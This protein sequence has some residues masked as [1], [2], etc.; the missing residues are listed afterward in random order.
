MYKTEPSGKKRQEV[1]VL[2]D[3]ANLYQIENEEW[4]VSD[5]VKEHGIGGADEV[6][7]IDNNKLKSYIKHINSEKG[8]YG[9][10]TKG[11]KEGQVFN[12]GITEVGDA[13]NL[14]ID[15]NINGY[16]LEPIDYSLDSMTLKV[17]G[18]TSGIFLA[19]VNG[20]QK[21]RRYQLSYNYKKLKGTLLSFGGHMNI[22]FG[23][24]GDNL[25]F[26]K[27]LNI[28][29]VFLD[30]ELNNTNYHTFKSA[31]KEG[32]DNS[33]KHEVVVEF[34][35][36]NSFTKNSRIYIQPN[37]GSTNPV[38]VEITDLKLVEL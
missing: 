5:K 20:M 1:K 9:I 7:L 4:P 18:G 37:R 25:S 33:Q 22:G 35:T 8:D 21:N 38:T 11:D 36:D 6:Y 12:M 3:A 17:S 24:Y 16:Y 26:E 32:Q 23:G 2:E 34:K 31:F 27:K 30:G 10:A 13:K 15:S 14:L 28:N 29:K 19:N